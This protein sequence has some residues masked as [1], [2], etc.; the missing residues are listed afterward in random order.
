MAVKPAVWKN[1]GGD[2]GGLKRLTEK[3]R[4][5]ESGKIQTHESEYC[6]QFFRDENECRLR[7]ET[8]ATH[9]GI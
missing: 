5:L 7:F 1:H 8:S 4:V 6:G 9:P 2:V 3:G